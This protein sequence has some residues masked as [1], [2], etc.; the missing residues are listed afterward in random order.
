MFIFA[1][2]ENKITVDVCLVDHK[3][4]EQLLQ[5]NLIII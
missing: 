1:L 5:V 4:L 2:D 3:D